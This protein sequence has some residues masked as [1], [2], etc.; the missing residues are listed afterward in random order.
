MLKNKPNS[1]NKLQ[2]KQGGVNI[3]QFVDSFV[4]Q[5]SD[6]KFSIESEQK[7]KNKF[8]NYCKTQSE[9][10]LKE[11]EK[12]RKDP[13]FKIILDIAKTEVIDELKRRGFDG[14]C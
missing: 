3:T 5:I 12:L 1:L 6:E 10:S 9:F 8:V 14:N 7:I 4:E 2:K 11:F 13:M